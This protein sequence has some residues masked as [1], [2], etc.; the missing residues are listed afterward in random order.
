MTSEKIAI[1]LPEDREG[2]MTVTY[3][4]TKTETCPKPPPIVILLGYAG[5]SDETL[6]TFSKIYEDQGCITLRSD[7]TRKDR[8]TQVKPNKL[9]RFG[10]TKLIFVENMFGATKFV[11]VHDSAN[12]LSL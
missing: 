7:L 11:A 9:C 5:C 10:Y 2:Q 8:L 12:Y 4:P 1:D 6:S 3:P